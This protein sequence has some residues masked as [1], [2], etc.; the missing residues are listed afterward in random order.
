MDFSNQ[1]E[2][3]RFKAQLRENLAP[4]RVKAPDP[5][6]FRGQVDSFALKEIGF[7]VVRS[8]KCRMEALSLKQQSDDARS[9][10]LV[11]QR[12]GRS[13]VE[14][15]GKVADLTAGDITAIDLDTWFRLDVR[16]DSDLALFVVPQGIVGLSDFMVDDY[17]SAE[18]LN[19]LPGARPIHAF[20]SE[21]SREMPV[22]DSLAWRYAG[23]VGQLA[24]TL[25]RLRVDADHAL[26]SSSIIKFEQVADY[27]EQHLAD[28]DL[29]PATVATD[30][31]VSPRY[32]QK[33]FRLHGMTAT[34]WIRHR[35]LEQ[36]RQALNDP[37]NSEKSVA[38]I[39]GEWGFPDAPY[40][41]RAFRK[42]YGITPSSVR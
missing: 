32:L 7:L 31:H 9:Y 8:Q 10:A 39:A 30:L 42:E 25:F 17:V 38:T 4:M 1:T 34:A 18:L 40:F 21:L 14:Q 13:Q 28:Q 41:S 19:D 23:V 27:V 15:A 3:G 37:K 12:S 11:L 22:P 5:T 36:C 26:H 29:T 16:Q 6:R 24:E 33:L 35:G 2:F 20:L